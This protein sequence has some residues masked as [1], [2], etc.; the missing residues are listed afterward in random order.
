MKAIGSSN[1]YAYF[2]ECYLSDNRNTTIHNFLGQKVTHKVFF[3]KEELINGDYP[4]VPIPEKQGN[5]LLKNTR[6]FEK[7]REL[8]YGSVFICGSYVD[9]RGVLQS[10]CSPLFYSNVTI[11]KKEDSHFAR[12]HLNSLRPNYP[13]LQLLNAEAE[14]HGFQNAFLTRIAQSTISFSTIGAIAKCLNQFFPNMNCEELYGFPRHL[15][16]KKTRTLLTSLKSSP[17][18]YQ[19]IP[20]SVLGMIEKS[21]RTRGVLNELQ[22]LGEKNHNSV[23]M[24]ILFK[25]GTPKVNPTNYKMGY[26]PTI[27][28]SAQKDILQSA[29]RNPLT[30]IVGPPGTGK[31]YSISAIALEHLSKGESVLIASRTDEAVDVVAK[32]IKNQLGF[33]HCIIRGGRKREHITKVRRF[34]KNLLVR[35]YP[36]RFLNKTYQDENGFKKKA[37]LR[38]YVKTMN[39]E[40]N[41]RSKKTLRLARSYVNSIAYEV[42]KSHFLSQREPKLW[43]ELKSLWYEMH[44]KF[45]DENKLFKTMVKI[46]ENDTHLVKETKSFLKWNYTL[47]LLDALQHHWHHLN[48][49]YKALNTSSDTERNRIFGQIDFNLVLKAFP[50]WLMNLSELK[51]KL[52]LRNELFDVV[53]IDEATQCDIATCLPAIYRAKRVV[54]AGDPDQLRHISFLSKNIQRQLQRKYGLQAIDPFLLNYRDN[55][56]LDLALNALEHQDQISLLD[57]HYRSLPPIASFNNQ[58]FYENGLRVMT[59]KPDCQEQA[60]YTIFCRGTRDSKGINKVEAV[61]LLK[62]L[63]E[64]MDLEREFDLN[65]VSSIGILTPF[66][67]QME[68]LTDLLLE[69]LDS[70]AINR[71]KI[72]IGTP[73]SFQ[74]E[75]RDVMLISMVVDKNTHHSAH[76]HLNKRDVFNVAVSRARHQQFIFHSILAN[77]MSKDDLLSKYLQ[78]AKKLKQIHSGSTRIYHDKF[79]DQVVTVLEEQAYDNIWKDY[80]I[81]DI[82][83]DILLKIGQRYVAI[84]LV[85]YPGFFEE[86]LG[87]DRIR[88]LKRATIDVF[89]ISFS[90]W[91][92]ERERSQ[93]E[94]V[95]FLRNLQP[96]GS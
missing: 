84:D 10:L 15:T 12:I 34:L 88:I 7:E 64:R 20:F 62:T 8:L 18:A 23:P 31:T 11:E 19:A 83:L 32:K 89:P 55:S 9:F 40:I 17:N 48:T 74:G 94:L 37:D 58:E 46:A 50:I 16:P 72:K 80:A 71:H 51:D 1:V 70:E 14:D 4:L 3:E 61:T 90:D 47:N 42:E 73:Y 36:L 39:R 13:L 78:H 79:L 86:A 85:G 41:K 33:E 26:V 69:K 87:V 6:L 54:F 49:F 57:E 63:S 2:R 30:V 77:E 93:K 65:L 25:F 24:N 38:D 81:A 66:R 29:G 96:S 35:T 67:S 44:A 91:Y 27:L 43:H 5:I 60:I 22:Q 28:S 56:I 59:K 21:K 53:I 75:E 52:P 45:A 92:F 76:L 95:G 68:F 82:T